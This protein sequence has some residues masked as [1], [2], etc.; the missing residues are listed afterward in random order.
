LGIKRDNPRV[1]LIKCQNSPFSHNQNSPPQETKFCNKSILGKAKV[2]TLFFK[3]HK[4]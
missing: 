1:K 2:L 3:I 4:W